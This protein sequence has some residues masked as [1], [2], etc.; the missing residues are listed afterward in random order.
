[1]PEMTAFTKHQPCDC[2]PPRGYQPRGKNITPTNSGGGTGPFYT[3][4]RTT[5]NPYCLVLGRPKLTHRARRLVV[6]VA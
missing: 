1:M 5:L 2:G 6:G 4:G 3:S